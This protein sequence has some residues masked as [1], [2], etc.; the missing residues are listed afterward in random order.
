[1]EDICPV[2]LHSCWVTDAQGAPHSQGTTGVEKQEEAKLR[3]VAMWAPS[4]PAIKGEESFS[5]LQKQRESYKS[6][7]TTRNQQ[8]TP[9][10]CA[11]LACP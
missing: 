6:H 10:L 7:S 5:I 11:P 2:V 4:P 8:A 3:T 1:M 9:L